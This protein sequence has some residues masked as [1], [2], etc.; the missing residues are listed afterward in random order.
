LAR[1]G[2]LLFSFPAARQVSAAHLIWVGGK[3][4]GLVDAGAAV[5]DPDLLAKP[6]I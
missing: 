3:A 1:P 5:E 4:R 2:T 6:K